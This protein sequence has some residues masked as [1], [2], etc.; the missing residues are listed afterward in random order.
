MPGKQS[1]LGHLHLF[2]GPAG[3]QEVWA[4]RLGHGDP[5]PSGKTASKQGPFGGFRSPGEG[6][7]AGL[8]VQGGPHTSSI[9]VAWKRVQKQTLG[10]SRDLLSQKP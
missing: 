10:L 6:C 3:R 2:L 9:T 4:A 5:G 7:S 1:G 8:V